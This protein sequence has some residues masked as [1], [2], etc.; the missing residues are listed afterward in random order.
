MVASALLTR[1]FLYVY[2]YIVIHNGVMAYGHLGQ[3]VMGN[4]ADHAGQAR[5]ERRVAL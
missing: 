5:A 2:P 3:V 4:E 1:A